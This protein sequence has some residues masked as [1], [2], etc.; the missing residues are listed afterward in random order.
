MTMHTYQ[1][2]PLAIF[3]P[4]HFCSPLPIV[5][6]SS[7]HASDQPPESKWTKMVIDLIYSIRTNTH[8]TYYIKNTKATSIHL[9][10]TFRTILIIIVNFSH[11]LNKTSFF[12]NFDEE[13]GKPASQS[14]LLVIWLLA[15]ES[16]IKNP[17]IVSETEN[18][19]L[20]DS[21]FQ[22]FHPQAPSSMR[23]TSSTAPICRTRCF[24]RIIP[25]IL[26]TF[27]LFHDMIDKCGANIMI[28]NVQ[29]HW[30]EPKTFN[31]RNSWHRP[32]FQLWYPQVILSKHSKLLSPIQLWIPY[33]IELHCRIRSH[34][35][36]SILPITTTT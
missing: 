34:W 13:I 12:E 18:N 33:T 35:S 26:S 3:R 15:P 24:A 9:E 6:V 10:K 16:K 28:M 29:I 8:N 31:H 22:S 21:F 5:H 32:T 36:P 7:V 20:T 4:I 2:L 14:K 17:S 1:W 11:K 23:K 27:L 30:R 19:I 25:T